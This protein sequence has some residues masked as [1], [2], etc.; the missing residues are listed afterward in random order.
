[1]ADDAPD[2]RSDSRRNVNLQVEYPDRQAYRIDT[3]ESV[4]PS[5]IFIR[6]SQHHR[7]GE[8]LR[9]AVSLPGFPVTVQLTGE[10]SRIREATATQSRGV[11]LKINREEFELGL[12][13]LLSPT[14][15]QEFSLSSG[16]YSL[17]A[18]LPRVRLA[19]TPTPLHRAERLSKEL[20][21]PDIWFKRDDLTGFATGGNKVRKMELVVADALEEGAD[22]LV[23]ASRRA[24]SA[25]LRVMA[26]AAAR[27]G[28]HAVSVARKAL[29]E[30]GSKLLPCQVFGSEI[31]ATTDSNASLDQ[32]IDAMVEKQTEAGRR[33]Y[34]ITEAD[35]GWLG[36][37]GYL[38]ASIEIL[39]QMR[40][41]QLEAD[42]MVCPVGSAETMAGLVVAQRWLDCKY[43]VL[44]VS[45]AKK[46][47]WCAERVATLAYDTSSRM[48]IADTIP[49]DDIWIQ[50]DFVG[51]GP[52]T[53]S[54]ASM[55]A[56]RL[57]ARCEGILLNPRVSGKAMAGLI[58]L[59][60]E[61]EFRKG[62][63]IVFLNTGG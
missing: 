38:L 62:Q 44:G 13:A 50:D 21:G 52:D 8:K 35:T 27:L 19:S 45:V 57:V 5:G 33:A 23:A 40:R 29:P 1:M 15:S 28:L 12:G 37:C 18:A 25:W 34:G 4:S 63:T 48:Q 22:T 55:E 16:P 59:I 10:V 61:G 39:A 2:R 47:H 36:A 49:V 20:D 51:K 17:L 30:Q 60:E 24:D 41:L 31:H 42:V 7:L 53:V 56:T 3:T 14:K 26:A 54:S 58:H 32:N 6:S 46:Q 9:I 11:A 43:D